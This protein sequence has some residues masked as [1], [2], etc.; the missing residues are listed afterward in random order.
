MKRVFADTGYWVALLNPS[1]DLNAKAMEVSS[2]LGAVRIYTTEMV[3]VEVAN[4]LGKAG[5]HFR[6]LVQ[7]TIVSLRQNAN[8]TIEPQTSTL[9]REA[10]DFYAAHR[11]KNWSLTDCASFLVM[12]EEGITEALAHDHHFEQAGFR[13]LLRNGN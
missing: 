11:D 7:Q 10:L 6:A 8:V 9:F 3:L 12:K 13:A 5:E 1:D 4:M 2:R